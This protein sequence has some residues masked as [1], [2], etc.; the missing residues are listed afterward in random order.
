MQLTY[1]GVTYQSQPVQIQLPVTYTTGKYR[2]LP[3]RIS[4]TISRFGQALISLK[5]R[6]VDYTKQINRTSNQPVLDTTIA[7]TDKVLTF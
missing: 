6:G 2:G 5:Y 3:A 7:K 4:P 1:R